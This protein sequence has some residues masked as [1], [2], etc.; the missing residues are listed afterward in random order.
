M[1]GLN[2]SAFTGLLDD[3]A[4]DLLTD[5]GEPYPDAR[6]R[7][8][9]GVDLHPECALSPEWDMC[10]ACRREMQRAAGGIV[11]EPDEA[12]GPVFRRV[13]SDGGVN[14]GTPPAEVTEPD[15]VLSPEQAAGRERVEAFRAMCSECDWYA[16]TPRE[17]IYTARSD[18]ETHNRIN[19]HA[20]IG[21]DV[22]EVSAVRVG[23]VHI[24]QVREE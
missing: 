21:A 3:H 17:S 24:R 13:L 8:A 11:L 15:D 6:S 19:D 23:S 16:S 1:S 12:D 9:L 7:S 4:D 2:G 10:G 18:A 20:S 14:T 5:G 22:E